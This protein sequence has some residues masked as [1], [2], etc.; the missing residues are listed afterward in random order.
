MN[1]EFQNI[2]Q[3]IE[4]LKIER[5]ALKRC[6]ANHGDIG[7]WLKIEPFDYNME[8]YF[9]LILILEDKR[10]NSVESSIDQIQLDKPLVENKLFK[11]FIKLRD[12]LVGE[13][14]DFQSH[15]KE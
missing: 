11:N 2:L 3:S 14:N 7:V 13:L 8:L 6:L 12:E 1:E 9:N 5:R 4:Q 15:S 10:G